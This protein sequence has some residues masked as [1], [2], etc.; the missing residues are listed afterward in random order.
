M[1]KDPCAR[2]G[3]ARYPAVKPTMLTATRKSLTG[4]KLTFVSM[5]AIVDPVA[6]YAPQ[7][8]SVTTKSAQHRL[9][10]EEISGVRRFFLITIQKISRY[11]LLKNSGMPGQFFL[12]H[13]LKYEYP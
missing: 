11:E 9:V 3:S 12:K 5:P 4:V 10:R 6:K 13:T 7:A 8:W 1:Q 2:T